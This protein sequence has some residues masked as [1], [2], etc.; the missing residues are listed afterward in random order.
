VKVFHARYIAG[1][2]YRPFKDWAQL[3]VFWGYRVNQLLARFGRQKL[4]GAWACWGIEADF[5]FPVTPRYLNLENLLETARMDAQAVR[6][7]N[8]KHLPE[9]F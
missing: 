4:F 8:L 3:S 5:E 1:I 6:P 2:G 7:S 9:L